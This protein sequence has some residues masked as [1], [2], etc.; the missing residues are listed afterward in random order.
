MAT[1]Q[2]TVEVSKEMSELMDGLAKLVGVVTKQLSDGFQAGDDISPIIGSTMAD[3]LPAI[4]GIQG[5]GDEATKETPA[6]VKATAIGG[7]QIY[8]AVT[9]NLKK[10]TP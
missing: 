5:L 8:A 4:N 1:I 6:F 2:K 9:E 10:K 7:A 3:L